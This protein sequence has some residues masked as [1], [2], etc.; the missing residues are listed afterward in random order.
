MAKPASVLPDTN[1]ILRYLL[2]DHTEHYAQA[3]A[4]FEAV[5]E[6]HRQAL[7]LESV[8]TECVYVLHKFY[9]VPRL[10]VADKLSVLLHYKGIQNEDRSDLVDALQ[11]YGKSKLDWVDCLLLAKEAG[12]KFEIFSF[13]ADLRK[14]S[15][16]S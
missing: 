13:D 1:V 10:E 3:S 5:R 6:G 2:A 11:R 9:R 7:I 8:L 16:A 15:T 14:K 12:G 4:F